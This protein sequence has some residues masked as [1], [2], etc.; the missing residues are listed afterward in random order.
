[1]TNKRR[2]SKAGKFVIYKMSPSILSRVRGKIFIRWHAIM[3]ICDGK[4]IA[5]VFL[6]SAMS[7]TMLQLF[8]PLPPIDGDSFF[9]VLERTSPQSFTIMSSEGCINAWWYTAKTKKRRSIRMFDNWG[10]VVFY[11]GTFWLY[12]FS[13]VLLNL[14]LFASRFPLHKNWCDVVVVVVFFV[15]FPLS[16]FTQKKADKGYDVVL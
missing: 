7:F 8:P 16:F 15:S 10:L 5:I 1:M 12:K 11:D 2:Q 13:W 3:T 4:L 9:S 14:I 6:V